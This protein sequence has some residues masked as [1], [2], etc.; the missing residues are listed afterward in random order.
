MLRVRGRNQDETNRPSTCWRNYTESP[1]VPPKYY[2]LGSHH[3]LFLSLS[4][5]PPPR[6]VQINSS[7]DTAQ[8]LYFEVSLV[9]YSQIRYS[10][11]ESLYFFPLFMLPN[12]VHVL[13]PTYTSFYVFV[14]YT[15][16]YTHPHM[17]IIYLLSTGSINYGRTWDTHLELI[18]KKAHCIPTFH[19]GVSFLLFWLSGCIAKQ[20]KILYAEFAYICIGTF[21]QEK[22]SY[23]LPDS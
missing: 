23:L 7:E 9:L 16:L 13:F 8:M 5:T 19:R 4:P 3:F 21:S 20:W 2:C 14:H 11:S 22:D 1:V 6:N 15:A 12:K 17:Q 10:S 18:W